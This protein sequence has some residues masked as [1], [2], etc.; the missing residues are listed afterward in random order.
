MKEV[1]QMK[2]K[3]TYEK[4]AETF[5]KKGDSAWAKAKNGEGEHNYHYAKKFYDTAKKAE[6]KARKM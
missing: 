2:S 5:R 4:V 6:E 3:K 1:Y